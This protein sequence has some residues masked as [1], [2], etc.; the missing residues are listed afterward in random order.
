VGLP[1]VIA[2]YGDVRTFWAKSTFLAS[3]K[4]I[5]QRCPSMLLARDSIA[6]VLLEQRN[7]L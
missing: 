6:S 7:K 2:Y 5:S 1:D 4:E 3:H